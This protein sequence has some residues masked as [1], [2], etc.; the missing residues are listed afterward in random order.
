MRRGPVS[1]ANQGSMRRGG[2]A[3]AAA[4]NQ[5]AAVFCAMTRCCV[6]AGFDALCATICWGQQQ[7]QEVY[8]AHL[9]SLLCRKVQTADGGEG[10]RGVAFGDDGGYGTCA[11]GFFH[12]PQNIVGAFGFHECNAAGIKEIDDALG[13]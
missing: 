12:A 11:Q 2:H 5:P 10:R 1:A 13:V 6:P 4:F 8:L 9:G 3:G 7:G